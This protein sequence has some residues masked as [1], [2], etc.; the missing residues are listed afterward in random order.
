MFGSTK[1]L[2]TLNVHDKGSIHT[3]LDTDDATLLYTIHWTPNSASHMTVFHTDDR[4]NIAGT[5]TYHATKKLG[6]STASNITLG[7]PSG[8][9]SLNKEGGL[10]SSDKRTFRSAELGEVHWKGGY[11]ETGFMKLVDAN[12]KSLVEYKAQRVGSKIGTLE[13]DTELGQE[14]LDEV[15][16]SG[17]AMLSEE[18]TS[19]SAT[20]AAISTA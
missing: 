6:I 2:R 8:T 1:P 12:G 7:L 17:I 10:F 4:N 9:V 5:A 11:S 19:M 16:V 15:V 3:I 20:A 13:I 18:A 14:G